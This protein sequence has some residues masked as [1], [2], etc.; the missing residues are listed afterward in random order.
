ME[1]T[2]TTSAVRTVESIPQDLQPYVNIPPST[3]LLFKVHLLVP[4][5]P[6]Y[7]PGT[8][9]WIEE[10]IADYHITIPFSGAPTGKG[11]KFFSHTIELTLPNLTT[12][13]TL[14]VHTTAPNTTGGTTILM[15]EDADG[16]DDIVGK[17]SH[18][19]NG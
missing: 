16:G 2:A 19:N 11:Q 4:Y 8:V 7:T 10:G 17:W 9:T 1:A 6:G 12:V 15:Y 13:A 5:N 14:N 18:S 3:T